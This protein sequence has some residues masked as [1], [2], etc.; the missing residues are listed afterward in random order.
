MYATFVVQSDRAR[1][2]TLRE[3]TRE[4]VGEEIR[5]EAL[6]LFLRQGFDATRT[7]DIAA[8]AGISARSFFRYFATKEDVLVGESVPF[9]DQVLIALKARPPE[10]P[11]WTALR[12][13]LDPLVEAMESQAQRS[14]DMNRIIMS[15]P[16]LRA[17][18][19]EK[20]LAWA[21]LLVPEVEKRIEENGAS[22]S[23]RASTLV[24]IAMAC[25]DVTLAE[26]VARDGAIK[27]GDLLDTVFTHA[28]HR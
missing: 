16:S 8:A 24:H 1:V 20:H 17:H 6:A 28:Q 18:H 19:F 10:E 2:R 12:A 27:F 15:T 3:R 4:A 23:L 21:R 9:G 22:P 25:L 13:A 7:E 11:T 14:L 26:W 5:R